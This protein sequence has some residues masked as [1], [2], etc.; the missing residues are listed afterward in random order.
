[1]WGPVGREFIGAMYWARSCSGISL[2][3]PALTR[4]TFVHLQLTLTF[5]SGSGMVGF[6]TGLNVISQHATCNVVWVA[7]ALV[8]TVA[9]SSMRTLQRIGWVGWIGLVCLSEH[10]GPLLAVRGR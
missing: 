1:M 2:T 5:V 10:L 7:I 8:L 3:G 9:I 4:T 6:G